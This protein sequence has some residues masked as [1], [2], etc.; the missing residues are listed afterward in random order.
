LEGSVASEQMFYLSK[1]PIGSVAG[2]LGNSV[3]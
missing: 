1:K 3:T 2:H